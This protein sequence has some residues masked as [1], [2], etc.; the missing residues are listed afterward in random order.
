MPIRFSKSK[1]KVG[2]KISQD[3]TKAWLQAVGQSG[4]RPIQNP[5]SLAAQHAVK[6][7]SRGIRELWKT[8]NEE[9]HSITSYLRHS[10][11]EA[12]AYLL[13]F[14]RPN[15]AKMLELMQRSNLLGALK[16]DNSPLKVVDM[17]CGTGAMSLGFIEAMEF[18]K[19]RLSLHLIDRRRHLC[20]LAEIQALSSGLKQT[21]IQARYQDLR[22]WFKKESAV[23][24]ASQIVLMGYLL[25]EIWQDKEVSGSLQH[26]L[27]GLLQS[28]IPNAVVIIDSA[29]QNLCR[30]LMNFRNDLC[31][32]GWVALYP[33]PSGQLECPLLERG[34]DWCFSEMSWRQESFDSAVDKSLAVDRS[35]LSFSA[36]IF[37]NQAWMH[38]YQAKKRIS[39]IVGRPIVDERVEYLICQKDIIQKIPV[40]GLYKKR[41]LLIDLD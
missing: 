22:L 6:E 30:Q 7:N 20:Q 28:E 21:Q 13:G 33:C 29:N 26:Y 36:F 32:R 17:G 16:A 40:Q 18:E 24:E 23:S 34:R 10:Q 9:R 39:V 27:S 35:N 25:N 15:Q 31:Q 5:D 8:F 1:K 11:K 4:R 2:L 38:K 3:G 14:H 19:D 37:V 12:A 41:G